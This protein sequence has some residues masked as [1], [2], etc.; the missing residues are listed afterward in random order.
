MPQ[1]FKTS[2]PLLSVLSIDTHKDWAGK[3]ITNIGDI[4]IIGGKKIFLNK[5]KTAYIFYEVIDSE[6]VRLVTPATW[7]AF[8]VLVGDVTKFGVS[9]E[10]ARSYVNLKVDKAIAIQRFA[11]TYE[12]TPDQ[13]PAGYMAFWKNTTVGAERWY[14]CWNDEGVVRTVELT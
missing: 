6:P 9:D 11:Q 10:L 5:A 7:G 1:A 2:R 3:D 4:E 14:I 13:I 12:P 8:T